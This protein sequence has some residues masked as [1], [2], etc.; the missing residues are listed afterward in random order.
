MNGL[1]SPETFS[2]LGFT[3][4]SALNT[5]LHFLDSF[6]T[7]FNWSNFGVSIAAGI[8]TFFSTF[9]FVLAADTAN[10]W[11]NGI[12]TTL[13]KAVQGTNWTMIGEKIGEFIKGID[14]I[15]ILSNIGTLIFEAIMAAIKAWNG[16]LML[17]R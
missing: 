7:K 14:F 16:F 17:H 12:L 4:A 2:I 13:I 9:D 5:A 1:I 3:I 8:N 15:D 6:G 11:I 10:K